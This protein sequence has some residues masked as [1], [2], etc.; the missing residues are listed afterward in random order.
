MVRCFWRP[1]F[2]C[3][4]EGCAARERHT[5]QSDAAPAVPGSARAQHVTLHCRAQHAWR[6]RAAAAAAAAGWSARSRRGPS[7][8]L[9]Q[10]SRSKEA[11][12]NGAFV[13]PGGRGARGL[14]WEYPT[15]TS[16]PFFL[17][18]LG[19]CPWPCSPSQRGE[20]ALIQACLALGLTSSDE[21]E[22]ETSW[23]WA[24]AGSPLPPPPPPR[25]SF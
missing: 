24:W 3:N 17:G 13:Q 19:A 23:S 8:P 22:P 7:E 10:G 4:Q 11:R 12:I 15:D 14:S 20:S 6:A 16:V 21:S 9:S 25:V 2:P 5:L 1:A 18:Q